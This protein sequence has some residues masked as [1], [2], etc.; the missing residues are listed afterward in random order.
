MQGKLKIIY[1]IVFSLVCFFSHAQANVKLPNIEGYTT[2]KADLHMHTVFS[3]GLV[4]PTF[5]I[6][7][8]LKEGIQVISITEH[9]EYQPFSNF[10]KG[11]LNKS[12]EIAKKL[13][14]KYN[15]I[16]LLGAEIT[17]SMPP[18]HSNAIFLTDANKLAT[19]KYQDAYEEARRQNAFIFWNHPC[20]KAQQPVTVKWWD[21]H[22]KL[23]EA[24][25]IQGIE[26]VNGV[27]YC[28]EAHRWCLEKN[29]TMIGNSDLHFPSCFVYS[30]NQHRP[31]TLLFV[32]EV[33]AEGCH[34]ALL[35]KRTLVMHKYNLYGFKD[36]LENFVRTCIHI[37]GIK[38][39]KKKKMEITM[40]NYSSIPYQLSFPELSSKTYTISEGKNIISIIPDHEIS[41][42]IQTL[43][44]VVKNA[45][46][47]P[48]VNLTLTYHF[49]KH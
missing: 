10:V 25:L 40:Q 41:R 13:A 44:V 36:L 29:L 7:E 20:W 12:Y 3:D 18:G 47:E 26:I 28:P 31:I 9:V 48:D 8:A 32:K 34:E 33:S 2:L 14:E 24:G 16:L 46:P 15:I 22:T 11:D 17:R 37:N 38:P 1:Y 45:F 19:E 42:E 27:T 49:D 21:E 35:S 6:E 4:W 5:R 23:Y 39:G 43:R 30:G